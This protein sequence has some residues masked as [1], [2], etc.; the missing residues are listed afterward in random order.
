M[1]TTIQINKETLERLKTFKIT[2]R[3]TYEEI[4][5]RLMDK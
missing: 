1:K 4:I 2:K 3:D 5:N